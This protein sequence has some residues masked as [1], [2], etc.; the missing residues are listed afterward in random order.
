MKIFEVL[1]EYSTPF[2]TGVKF[3]KAIRWYLEA[4]IKP[5]RKGRRK[6]CVECGWPL[7]YRDDLY[8]VP[9]ESW[10]PDIVAICENMNCLTEYEEYEFGY[11]DTVIFP[12]KES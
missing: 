1:K 5:H 7:V 6:Y 11:G 4:I 10:Y 3:K 9:I 2:P 8:D 12:I